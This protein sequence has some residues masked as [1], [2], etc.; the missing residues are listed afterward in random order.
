MVRRS[1]F[2]TGRGFSKLKGPESG[3]VRKF[4]EDLDERRDAEF[5]PAGN[6]N[7]SVITADFP[8]CPT[9]LPVN[10]LLLPDRQMDYCLIKVS[11][12]SGFPEHVHGY[13]DELY[14]V[15][16]GNG[17]V[18]LDGQLYE[19]GPMDIFHI[20]PGVAHELFNPGDSGA[21]LEIFAVNTPA[22]HHELRSDYWGIPTGREQP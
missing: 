5:H 2:F 22:V 19:A 18:R 21:T 11:P 10:W 15:I 3:L 1:D 6:L 17:C 14:L 9:E 12:G 16:S 4:W 13:G 20:R 7:K 8:G